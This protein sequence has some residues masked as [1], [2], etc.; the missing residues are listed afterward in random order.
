MKRR[1]RK[2]DAALMHVAGHRHRPLVLLG[3]PCDGVFDSAE[4]GFVGA[5]PAPRASPI[6]APGP[7]GVRIPPPIEVVD[8]S[9]TCAMRM[10]Q[11]PSGSRSP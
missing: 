1:R 4:S 9:A 3:R 7:F 6:E 2:F 10:S 8:H 5:Q 11:L